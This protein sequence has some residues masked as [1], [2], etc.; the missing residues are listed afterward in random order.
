MEGEYGRVMEMMD[1]K[2][3]ESLGLGCCVSLG[4]IFNSVS[5]SCLVYNVGIVA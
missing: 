1:F 5:P 3:M 4:T 2:V